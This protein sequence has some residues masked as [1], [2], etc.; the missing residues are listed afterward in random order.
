MEQLLLHG[1][2]DYIIQTDWMAQNK[3]KKGLMGFIACQ[4]HCITYS[5]PFF[6]IGSWQAVLAIYLS[7][8]AID[9]TKILD[10]ALAWKNNVKMG[11][12]LDISNF[13]FKRERPFAISVWLYIITDNV[14]H[15]ICNYFALKF[16]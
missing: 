5:L 14:L 7:H 3:K 16:L 8:F 13:G 11:K 10:Y 15:L 4:I 6:L 12:K 9:R 2:G 1:L